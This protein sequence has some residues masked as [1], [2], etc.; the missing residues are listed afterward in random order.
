[1]EDDF[2]RWSKRLVQT[3]GEDKVIETIEDLRELKRVL[4]AA[5]VGSGD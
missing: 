2:D 3:I 5:A 1:M 4:D